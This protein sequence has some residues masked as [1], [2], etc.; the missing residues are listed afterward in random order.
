M[1]RRRAYPALLALVVL[2]VGQLAALAHHAQTR[3]VECSDHGEELETAKLAQALDSC[4][5]DHWIGV[6]GDGGGDHDDCAIARAL[7]QSAR[8][9]RGFVA[10][11][12]TSIVTQHAA[13]SPE[14]VALSRELILFAPKTSPPV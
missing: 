13:T 10:P 14:D 11:A 3:H 8:V 4:E 6:E 2:V 5:Q 7:H 9:N 1:R 12:I